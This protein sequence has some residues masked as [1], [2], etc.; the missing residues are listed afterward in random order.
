[1]R[2]KRFV[3]VLCFCL[4]LLSLAAA[5]SAE[6]RVGGGSSYSGSS[7]RSSS[8]GSSGGSRSS[9]GSR[10]SGGSYSGGSYSGGSYSGG[11]GGNNR[12]PIDFKTLLIVLAI[13]VVLVLVV[14]L[15]SHVTNLITNPT[16][17]EDDNKHRQPQPLPRSF[18]AQGR[19]LDETFSEVLFSERAVMLLTR[20]L[21]AAHDP[22]ALEALSPYLMPG[23]LVSLR[24]RAADRT[25]GVTVGRIVINSL[26]RL[27]V[28]GRPPALVA[29]VD[30]H[31]NRH[32][33][34]GGV[35]ASYFSHEVWTFMKPIGAA[36]VRDDDTVARFGCP[37]CGSTI[38]RDSFGRCV[39][40]QTSLQPGDADW[41]VKSLH[42]KQQESAGPLLTEDVEELGTDAPTAIDPSVYSDADR[43]L[44]ADE[45]NRL[46]ARI[47][48]VF[49]NLQE[50]WSAGRLE[51]LRPFETDALFQSHR[52]WLEEYQ[53]QGLRNVIADL[54]IEGVELC[55]VEEDGAHLVAMCRIAAA[56]RDSTVNQSTGRVVGG[57]ARK[58]RRFTEYWT[59]VKHKDAKGSASLKSC[60]NCGAPVQVSQTGAC[61]FCQAKVTLGRFDWVASRIEQDEEVGGV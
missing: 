10:S 59:F 57:D 12:E 3:L 44:G 15:F 19:K 45:R 46:L 53:R 5:S 28:E 37:G 34:R 48:D 20:A 6:A 13:S 9:S 27:D 41:T 61:E 58:T 50:Q 32:T 54:E 26:R 39:H 30:F 60:P 51:G 8:G 38:E 2:L 4:P 52:F 40:C 11:G 36:V 56:C 22:A 29:K 23:V 14:A 42:V 16:D 1:M 21:Q 35:A 24:Q 31:L 49:A 43:L 18:A 55:R 33:E 47:R 7:S 17:D 25:V